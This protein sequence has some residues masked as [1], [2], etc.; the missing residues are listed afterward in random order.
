MVALTTE[1]SSSFF[2]PQLALRAVRTKK[3][4]NNFIETS[5]YTSQLNADSAYV[6]WLLNAN[7]L[8]RS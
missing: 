4:E 6:P 3:A 5:F 7:A 8:I 2:S 1:S